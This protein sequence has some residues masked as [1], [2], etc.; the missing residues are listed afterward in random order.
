MKKKQFSKVLLLLLILAPKANALVCP[1]KQD[2]PYC[3]KNAI[4]L[5]DETYPTQAFVISNAPQINSKESLEMTQKFINKI[6]KSYNYEN[7]PQIIMA[8]DMGDEFAD[9]KNE[10]KLELTNNNISKNKIEKILNQ[11]T[12]APISN[13]PW[14][15]D[16]F[17]AFVDLKTGAPVIKQ[18]YSYGIVQDDAGIQ[19][20]KAGETCNMQIGKQLKQDMSFYTG[21]HLNDNKSIPGG[22]MGGNIEGAPGGFCL[23]GDNLGKSVALQVCNEEDNIIQVKTSWLLVGHVDEIFKIIPT[24]FKDERPL[25]CE[26]S[27]MSASPKKALELMKDPKLGQILFTEFNNPDSDSEELKYSRTNIRDAGN[28]FLCQY[29][30]EAM[31]N[32]PKT[33]KVTSNLKNLMM[34]SLLLNVAKAD[35]V[36]MQE[37]LKSITQDANKMAAF[38]TS[39]SQNFDKVTNFELQAVMLTDSKFT[40]FNSA[41]DESIRKDRELIKNKILSRLPQCTKW[42]NEI[43]V[44][45]LFYGDS[46]IETA[47]KKLALSLPGTAGSFLPNPTNSVLMNKTI[48]FPDTGNKLF[49]QY[50]SQEM[51]KKNMLSD[52]IST[53]DY[54]HVENGNIH[55]VSHSIQHCRPN[56]IGQ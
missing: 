14:Q 31:R 22:E 3:P 1:N 17:E 20:A 48:L 43:E 18:M 32:R 9:F 45:N 47:D 40:K 21:P 30:E 52:F 2:A 19:I 33:K 44:P 35:E 46:A 38:T 24:H 12:L 34:S 16:Y 56:I 11:I 50:L 13:F 36:S 4:T 23:I 25:E 10:T 8:I 51:A 42:Y 54:G 26:F 5:L 55:C 7:V 15:Q 27:V 41:I 49:N 28:F 6:I 29:V 37:F 53:W 39:C